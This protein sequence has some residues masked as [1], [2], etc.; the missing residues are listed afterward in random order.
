MIESASFWCRKL[1]TTKVFRS[2]SGRFQYCEGFLSNLNSNWIFLNFLIFFIDP[3]TIREGFSSNSF[4]TK[5]S[6]Y[7]RHWFK[8]ETKGRWWLIWRLS[9]LTF[10]RGGYEL[11]EW[12][13]WELLECLRNNEWN[14]LSLSQVF[15]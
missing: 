10:R 13:F 6:S 14:F 11:R 9:V 2:A 4:C 15:N 7:H 5:L 1:F 3:I 12:C 8:M